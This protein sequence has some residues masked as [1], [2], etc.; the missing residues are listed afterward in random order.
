MKII[1]TTEAKETY[2]SNIRYLKKKWTFRE[3]EKFTNEVNDTLTKLRKLPE[4]GKY[5]SIWECRKFVI[6]KQITLF[7][8]I[9]DNGDALVLYSFWNNYKKPLED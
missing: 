8:D 4:L 1:W 7:Y 6:V 9:V 3:I 5:D 2:K